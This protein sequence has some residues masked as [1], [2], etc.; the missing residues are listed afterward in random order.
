MLMSSVR[1]L[2]P[3]LWIEAPRF[4]LLLNQLQ[5]PATPPELASVGKD[6]N[7]PFLETN[8]DA[9]DHKMSER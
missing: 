9:K 4:P 5:I 3:E 1:C 7:V 6:V 2:I 8:Q